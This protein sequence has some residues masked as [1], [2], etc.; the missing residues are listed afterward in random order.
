LFSES[1]VWSSSVVGRFHEE[2]E[3][4][5]MQETARNR[6][7]PPLQTLASKH[8]DHPHLRD[9]PLYAL[10]P[11]LLHFVRRFLPDLFSDEDAE[12]ETDLVE[13]T[14]GGFLFGH[15]F[16]YAPLHEPQY[17]SDAPARYSE[18]A[19]RQQ[20]AGRE[21]REMIAE[22]CRDEGL[23]DFQIER[24]FEVEEEVRD[25]V[26]GLPGSVRRLAHQQRRVSARTGRYAWEVGSPR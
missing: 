3:L 24:C 20:S 2:I 26:V 18:L 15:A 10:S 17:R 11:K 7:S 19:E 4:P 14:G 5:K 6:T 25:D 21:I 12:F 22:V 13:T 1:H 23:N 9:G 8:P 16:G